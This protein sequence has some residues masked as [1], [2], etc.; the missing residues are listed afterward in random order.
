[1][2]RLTDWLVLVVT[3]IASTTLPGCALRMAPPV[4]LP[5]TQTLTLRST[6]GVE[7][8]LLVS[9]PREAQ[10]DPTRRFPVIY[11]LDADYSF[12]VVRNVVEHLADRRGLPPAIIVGIGYPKGLEGEEW[13]RRYRLQ[14]TRDYTPTASSV[15]YPDGVQAVSGG[16]PRFLQFIERELVPFIDARLAT[17][18]DR[19]LVGHSYGGLFALY[20]VLTRPAL[21]TRVVSV[22]P[23]LWYDHHFLA[24][25]E[26]PPSPFTN[27]LFL[28]AGTLERD[29]DAGAI[30][31][32]VEA[33]ALTLTQRY[34]EAHISSFI[35]DAETHDS[36]F[37]AAVV[38][39]LRSV[40]HDRPVIGESFRK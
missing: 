32:D 12:A 30:A 25:L 6:D 36:V 39:G 35:F 19:T 13:L 37:P 5:R 28:G 10:H 9:V 27:A 16:G 3:L 40:F 2:R 24:R 11:L 38:R 15:G 14:R 20:A 8:T 21:F 17:T 26:S 31:N 18:T 22:S 33:F 1:M 34:P 23:S 29:L 7:Y 4:T